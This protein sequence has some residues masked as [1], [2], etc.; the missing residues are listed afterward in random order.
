LKKQS[1]ENASCRAWFEEGL[2]N[3]FIRLMRSSAQF[4][5]EGCP[6]GKAPLFYFQTLRRNH[7]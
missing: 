4:K 6:V 7:G 2:T 5:Q 3:V 1:F